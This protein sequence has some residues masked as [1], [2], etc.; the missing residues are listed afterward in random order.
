[1]KKIYYIIIFS[2]LMLLIV[3]GIIIGALWIINERVII[4]RIDNT[5]IEVN[6]TETL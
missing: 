4:E 3:C 2:V 5:K 1:M 6:K